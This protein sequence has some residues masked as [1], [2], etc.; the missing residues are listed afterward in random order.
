[1]KSFFIRR[2]ILLKKSTGS[3][4]VKESMLYMMVSGKRLSLKVSKSSLGIDSVPF[5]PSISWL[6][7]APA[8]INSGVISVLSFASV[9]MCLRSKPS[10]L[11]CVPRTGSF[12]LTLH[13]RMAVSCR[14]LLYTVGSL[15]RA[16][17]S[18]YIS[19]FD[20]NYIYCP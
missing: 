11:K 13:I 9:K 2:K 14:R 17:S 10:I 8:Q 18:L 1:M 4:M 19:A 3:Q 7:Q 12:S 16:R 6:L 20:L 15:G 5:H